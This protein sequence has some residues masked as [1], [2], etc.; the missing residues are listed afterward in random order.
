MNNKSSIPNRHAALL[1]AACLI[2][3]SSLSPAA[4]LASYDFTPGS[5]ATNGYNP[6]FTIT[7]VDASAIGF[8]GSTANQNLSTGGPSGATQHLNFGRGVAASTD[9][10][11]ARTNNVFAEFTLTA[12][13]NYL[14]TL[15]NQPLTFDLAYGGSAGMRNI[16]LDVSLDNFAT[17]TNVG[18]PTEAGAT[19][20]SVP[21]T[22]PDTVAF[23]NLT[24]ATPV[25]FRFY[26][27]ATSSGQ[28]VRIDNVDIN[29]SATLVPEPSAILLGLLGAL[30]LLRRRR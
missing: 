5:G 20:A 29:G 13:S 30:P 16:F 17:F 9:A 27:F 8:T 10:A 7:G 28:T 22:L 1:S 3:L 24:S 19:F 12:S 2:S 15:R 4:L 23:E 11:S 21:Y 14:L 26:S 6:S 25:G 18:G